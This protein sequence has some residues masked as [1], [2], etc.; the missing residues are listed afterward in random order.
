MK[1]YIKS[2]VKKYRKLKKKNPN[3][4]LLEYICSVN[5]NSFGI[6]NKK[7]FLKKFGGKESKLVE[8]YILYS[9]ELKDV[10]KNS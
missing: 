2:I 8:A 5:N 10:V 3:H 7:K 1:D 6:N 9:K 4:K